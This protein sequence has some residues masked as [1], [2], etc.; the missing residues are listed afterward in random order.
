MSSEGKQANRGYV[1]GTPRALR[2]PEPSSENARNSMRANRRRNTG[3]ERLLRLALSEAAIRGYR[4]DLK[5]AP[6]RPDI[7]FTRY[8]LAVFV[9]G[10]FWHR[11]PHCQL[12]M[13]KTNRAFWKRKFELNA[14]R[15]ERKRRGL[16]ALGWDVLEFW[17][18]EVERDAAACAQRVRRSIRKITEH[19]EADE[20]L[21]EM[22]EGERSRR[23]GRRHGRS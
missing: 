15:D 6:G 4:L 9:H 18:C 20:E 11:C 10:C 22:A 13:P 7:A 2:N 21:A 19:L 16:E 5:P 14:E 3:P 12:K 8:K 17:E 1:S 23:G